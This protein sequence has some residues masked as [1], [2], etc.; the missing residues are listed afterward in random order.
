MQ[1]ISKNAKYHFQKV[2]PATYSAATE[3]SCSLGEQN[4]S[5]SEPQ[6]EA[7]EAPAPK[8][9]SFS[10]F[11]CSLGEAHASTFAPASLGG[12]ATVIARWEL[13]NGSPSE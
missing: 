2:A 5:P 8:E 10:R 13:A 11:A 3:L 6:N 4:D 1:K 12:F 7:P 9:I